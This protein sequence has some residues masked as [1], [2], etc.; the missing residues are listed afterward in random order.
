MQK[1]TIEYYLEA[2]NRAIEFIESNTS[3]NIGLEEIAEYSLLSK[4]HF[5]RVF[6]SI[7][8]GTAKE[9]LTR[10]RVEK[11]ASLLKNSQK[12]I[13]D[14]AYQC[15]YASPETF[16]RAFKNYFSVSPSTFRENAKR[17]IASKKIIH[18][19]TSFESINLS[20]PKIVE[21]P[22][23]NLAYIRHFGSYDKVGKSFQRLMLWAAKNLVLKLKPTT[24]GIVH[25]NP[26]LTEEVNVRFD[27][28]IVTTKEI[29]PKGEIGYKQIKGGRFAVFRHKGPYESFYPVYDYIYNIC[30]FE[31][32]WELRDEPALE[33][34]VKSPPF[35][36]P[37]SFVTDFYLP[38]I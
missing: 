15:G 37:E 38:I 21:L 30:L 33:W 13:S 25:D 22:D 35:F 32:R 29:Q 20:Q 24:V 3:K 6:K 27:A 28:C 12:A 8:G 5:H 26:D 11:S 18:Q 16:N 10:L 34:Y 17:E 9:Y 2:V 1:E 23:L 14:I 4:Y 36:K 31:Q 19:E 7:I